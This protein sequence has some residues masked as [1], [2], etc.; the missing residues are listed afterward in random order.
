MTT[1]LKEMKI[2]QLSSLNERT[3][4]SVWIK[5]ATFLMPGRKN[6]ICSSN[7]R[8]N[9]GKHRYLISIEGQEQKWE[10]EKLDSFGAEESQSLNGAE[11]YMRKNCCTM[12]SPWCCF[13]MQRSLNVFANAWTTCPTV[14]QHWVFHYVL[15]IECSARLCAKST[16]HVWSACFC[17][18]NQSECIKLL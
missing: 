18:C 6:L 2:D 12:P 7:P 15:T 16:N 1:L 4:V 13:P 11:I 3:L 5:M 8:S 14:W 17:L 10:I 9:F